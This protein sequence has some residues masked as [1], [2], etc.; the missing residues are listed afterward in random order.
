MLRVELSVQLLRLRTLIVLAFLSGV[1]IVAGLATASHA[2]HRNGSQGGLF[3]ASTSSALNHTMASLQ[4]VAPLLLPVL[5]ALLASAVGSADREWGTLRYLYVQPVSRQRLLSGKLTAV[6]LLTATMIGCALLSGLAVGLVLFGWHPFHIINAPSLTVGA[7]FTRT[8]AA[9]GYTLL[10]MLSIAAI[11]FTLSLILPRGAEALGASIAFVIA[12]SILNAQSHLHLLTALLPVHYW[13]EWT[14]LFDA[15][16]VD[17]TA[18]IMA[19][20]VTIVL[21][22]GAAVL[23]LLRRDPSA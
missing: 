4:F 18:G 23:V 11:A 3:G 7:A 12:A 8:L 6:L 15:T 9:S 16:S 1:P 20:L 14:S 22:T 19:Q 17:L 2:G 5:V 13:Q 21:M 10:C